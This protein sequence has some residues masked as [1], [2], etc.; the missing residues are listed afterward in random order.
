MLQ[1]LGADDFGVSCEELA[2]FQVAMTRATE[3]A[4]EHPSDA[5][6][7]VMQGLRIAA[8]HADSVEDAATEE[9]VVALHRLH[10]L[11]QVSRNEPARLKRHPKYEDELLV[12]CHV[13]VSGDAWERCIRHG[14]VLAGEL[15]RAR[16]YLSI[17]SWALTG[18][19]ARRRDQCWVKLGCYFLKKAERELRQRFQAFIGREPIAGDC[20]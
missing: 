9:D 3:D 6:D 8:S 18:T 10:V 14:G 11:L 5:W 12:R 19:S 16:L 4:G 2:A 13:P 1:A 7:A 20:V 15:R 17:L